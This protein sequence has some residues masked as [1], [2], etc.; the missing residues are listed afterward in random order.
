MNHNSPSQN[1]NVHNSYSQSPARQPLFYND[2]N[3]HTDNYSVTNDKASRPDTSDNYVDNINYQQSNFASTYQSHSMINHVNNQHPPQSTIDNTSPPF[4]SLNMN[5]NYSQPNYSGILSF[6]IPGY[7][8]I[9][10]P[11]SS[12]QGY[13][14]PTFSQN[15]KT[16]FKQ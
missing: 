7:K 11:T 10:I 6:D 8:I 2:V 1:N 16:Q 9:F 5:I 14:K 13:L 4:H 15:Y 3:N 12:Q